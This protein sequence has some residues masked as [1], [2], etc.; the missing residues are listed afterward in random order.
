MK[1]KKELVIYFNINHKHTLEASLI[2]IKSIGLNGA[3]THR[4]L[5]QIYS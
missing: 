5:I 3:Q 1:Q 4:I 2:T